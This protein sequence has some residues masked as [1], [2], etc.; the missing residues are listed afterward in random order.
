MLRRVPLLSGVHRKELD[1]MA[2][3]MS[4]R[5]FSAGESAI[6]EGQPGAGFWLIE[7]GGA[8]VTL[9]GR[10]IRNLGPGD[11]FGEIALIDDGPRSAT[12][13]ATAEMTCRGMSPWE[14]KAF[15]AENPEA[16]WAVMRTLVGH[17]RESEPRP[18]EPTESSEQ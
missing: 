12:V 13:V 9:G 1:R 7:S 15:V 16:A 18:G 11:Y 5:T 8:D 6:E 3:R 14:F 17:L 10:H 4:T 2:K